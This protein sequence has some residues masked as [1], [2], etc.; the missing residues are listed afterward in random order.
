MPGN[1]K[2]GISKEILQRKID[3]QNN[4]KRKRRFYTLNEYEY[5][6]IFVKW[7]MVKWNE[8]YFFW[9]N[10]CRVKVR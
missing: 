2:T 5:K 4:V 6:N 8:V 7:A 3:Y 10:L 9:R 1:I